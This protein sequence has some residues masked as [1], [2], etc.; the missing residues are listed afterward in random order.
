VLFYGEWNFRV[1]FVNKRPNFR[2]LRYLVLVIAASVAAITLSACSQIPGVSE[3]VV[4]FTEEPSFP[5]IP[6]LSDIIPTPT[7]MSQQEE[8]EPETK[9][10]QEPQEIPSFPK[11]T[12]SVAIDCVP[13]AD[14][15]PS[16][17]E[18]PFYK[19]GSPQRTSLIEDDVIGTRLQLS[20]FV[21]TRECQPVAGALLDFWQA[22]GLGNYDNA[23]YRLRG[24]QYTDENGRYYLETVVPGVYPSRTPHIHVRVQ[25]LDGGLLITQIFFP[26][27]PSNLTDHIFSPQLVITIT[28]HGGDILQ[29]EFNFVIPAE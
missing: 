16:M 23:G 28:E 17:A 21:F 14:L 11:Q 15:T 2:R 1:K 25:P 5:L 29:G 10:D 8:D 13:T 7:L 3:E 6:T 26:D 18:G 12:N 9:G 20:G 24:H 27:E 22:D 19:T 4:D